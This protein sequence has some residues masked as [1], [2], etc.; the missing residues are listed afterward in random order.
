MSRQK[1]RILK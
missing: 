1:H